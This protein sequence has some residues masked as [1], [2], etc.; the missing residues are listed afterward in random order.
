M[1][2]TEFDKSEDEI[3]DMFAH[4]FDSIECVIFETYSTPNSDLKK[5]NASADISI[6]AASLHKSHGVQLSIWCADVM[7]QPQLRN[8]ELRD[9]GY[10]QAV[11]GCGLFNLQLEGS[12]EGNRI[13]GSF[14]Y[15]TESA[16]KNKYTGING[17]ELVNWKNHKQAAKLLKK[18]IASTGQPANKSSKKDALKRASS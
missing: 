6:N 4:I 16:A 10:R 5:F 12:K 7:P 2:W 18:A 3:N 8:I 11:D 15:F 17:P 13:V 14:G 9:G 1:S